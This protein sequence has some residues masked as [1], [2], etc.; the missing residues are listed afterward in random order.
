MAPIILPART[1]IIRIVIPIYSIHTVGRIGP[2]ALA[3]GI[4]ACREM[5]VSPPTDD[6]AFPAKGDTTTTNHIRTCS[7][8]FDVNT[9]I[10]TWT[11]FAKLSDALAVPVFAG[12]VL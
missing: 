11:P 8:L 3:R 6:L 2:F 10:S 4:P 7:I 5:L 9:T 1:F 12:L